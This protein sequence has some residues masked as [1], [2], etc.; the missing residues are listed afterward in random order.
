M[1]VLTSKLF[2]ADSLE[3]AVKT[4]AQTSVAL[5]TASGVLGLLTVN[6]GDLASIAGLAGLVSILTSIA[7]AGSGNSASLVVDSRAK[8]KGE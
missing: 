2:I 3:R 8:K 1:S 7:S 5:L 4:I 6:W